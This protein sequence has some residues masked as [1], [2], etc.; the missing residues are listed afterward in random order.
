MGIRVQRHDFR[1]SLERTSSRP[2]HRKPRFSNKWTRWEHITTDNNIN[3]STRKYNIVQHSDEWRAYE[4]L[5]REVYSH[6][7]VK[8]FSCWSDYNNTR[9]IKGVWHLIITNR[10]KIKVRGT[11][12]LL[13]EEHPG[14][15]VDRILKFK[16]FWQ[17]V[18]STHGL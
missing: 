9:T 18:K 4:R 17:Y 13:I 1:L 3:T 2:R 11:P 16:W 6:E 12:S 10:C 7:T 8:Q 14:R 5:N 15:S